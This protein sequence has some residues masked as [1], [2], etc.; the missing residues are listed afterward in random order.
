VLQP[1]VAKVTAV[2][3][4][5]SEIEDRADMASQLRLARIGFAALGIGSGKQKEAIY[6]L[7]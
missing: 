1:C 7:V 5:R 6:D 3:I 4:S 2:L